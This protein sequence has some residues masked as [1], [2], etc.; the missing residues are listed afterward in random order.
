MVFGYTD[1]D[2]AFENII[3]TIAGHLNMDELQPLATLCR[4]SR[5]IV[6][7]RLFR[8]LCFS[9]RPQGPGLADLLEF[10]QGIDGRDSMGGYIKILGISGDWPC[11]PLSSLSMNTVRLLLSYVPNICR[12]QLSGFMWETANDDI[13][14]IPPSLQEISILSIVSTTRTNSPLT[15]LSLVDQWHSVRI[16]GINHVC[17]PVLN[18]KIVVNTRILI[19][20]HPFHSEPTRPLLES[21]LEIHGVQLMFVH[22][23]DYTHARAFSQLLHDS[24]ETLEYLAVTLNTEHTCKNTQSIHHINMALTTIPHRRGA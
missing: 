20:E 16:S 5:P 21:A 8:V 3:K 17:I 7:A 18:S 6:Q 13:S 23:F 4:R 10:L 11:A 22:G 19:I 12:L 24:A 15:L 9:V 2:N 1:N 14:H